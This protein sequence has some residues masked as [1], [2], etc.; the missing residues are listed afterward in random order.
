MNKFR[1]RCAA[2]FLSAIWA[3]SLFPGAALAHPDTEG[4]T[5]LA[6]VTKRAMVVFPFDV[7]D[8]VPGASDVS[9]LL[10]DV[11]RS[12]LIAADTYLVVQF[13]KGLPPVARAHND[14]QLSDNDL[15]APYAEDNAKATKVTKTIGYELAFV[16]SVDNYEYKSDTKQATITISGRI[17]DTTNGKIVKSATLSGSSGTGGTS[18][19][20]ERAADAARNAAEKLMTQLGIQAR[21]SMTP[22]VTAPKHQDN[23]GRRKKNNNWLWGVLAIGLGLGIGLASGGG[24]GGGNGADNPPP[25][26]H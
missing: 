23:G 12:R 15:K 24:G 4:T 20:P 2:R 19:E 1:T 18:K 14:Q 22:P 26:P 9:G 3:V 25:P 7:P 6:Q 8:T 10:T 11:A 13:N 16:G 17:L 21:P 5:N